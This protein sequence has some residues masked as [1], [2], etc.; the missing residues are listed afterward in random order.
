M[1]A[2]RKRP[3][4]RRGGV[5]T[6]SASVWTLRKKNRHF[7]GHVINQGQPSP[8]AVLKKHD[9]PKREKNLILVCW[10]WES[11]PDSFKRFP[12]L[13]HAAD[14]PFTG[15][16]GRVVFIGLLKKKKKKS[17]LGNVESMPHMQRIEK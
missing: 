16:E 2:G 5:F 11:T 17:V 3:W 4:S 13:I 14:D 8:H 6:F 12:F 15:V 9:S 7:T 1:F 10:G